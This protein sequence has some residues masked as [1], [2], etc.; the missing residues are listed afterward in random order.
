MHS[1]SRN[2]ISKTLLFCQDARFKFLLYQF[3]LQISAHACRSCS[4]TDYI[5]LWEMCKDLKTSNSFILQ[6]FD[7][8]QARTETTNISSSHR[9]K[10]M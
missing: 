8:P 5:T 3:L 9:V 2:I 1:A 6:V 4:V 10:G 7:F